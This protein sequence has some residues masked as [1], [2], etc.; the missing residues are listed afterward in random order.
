MDG[1][2]LQIKNIYFE[3]WLRPLTVFL[4]FS[5]F[6]SLH[7]L[8]SAFVVKSLS[9]FDKLQLRKFH[10]LHMNAQKYSI[11]SFLWDNQLP[12]RSSRFF[13]FTLTRKVLPFKTD[14][15]KNIIDFK[16][17]ISSQF[18]INYPVKWISTVKPVCV[19]SFFVLSFCEIFLKCG[20]Y[21]SP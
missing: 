5:F 12:E 21:K 17:T 7:R 14:L 10:Y 19:R 20:I 13:N 3:L 18:Q 8:S 16:I 6:F 9:M 1:Q 15:E 4:S 2:G 11:N